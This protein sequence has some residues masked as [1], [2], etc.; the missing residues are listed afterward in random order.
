MK[1]IT[2]SCFILLLVQL[3]PAQQVLQGV[4][5]DGATGE[6]VP[7]ANIG[8]TARG[9]GTV[10]DEEGRFTLRYTETRDTVTVSSIGY[11]TVRLTAGEL[12]E[13]SVLELD[14]QPYAIP[15]VEVD[16]SRF[17]P[18]TTVGASL[19]ERH[20]SVGFGSPELGAEVAAHLEIEKETLVKS[21]HFYL[22]HAKG[23]QL[24]FR[25]N[26]YDFSGG[27]IGEN[28]LPENVLI[29][30]AQRPGLL[31]VDLSPFNLIV[32]DDVLLSLEMVQ[33]ESGRGNEGITFRGKRGRRG[34]NLYLRYTSQAP[35]R[36]GS[37]L[38]RGAPRVQLGF[39]LTGKEAE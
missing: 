39:Y 13:K 19:D 6:P 37:D 8:V 22:E 27:E 30:Q 33:D 5:R 3:L 25:V 26:L 38:V 2:L 4:L 16:A 18:E 1:T 10:S 36:K 14:P 12:A 23:E 29:R 34:D 20:H 11:R 9:A 7:F 17:G 35:F 32:S 28:L 24:I 21:A 15:T 31:S